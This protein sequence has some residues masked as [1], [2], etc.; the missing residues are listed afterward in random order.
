M[1]YYIIVSI[2]VI[3]ALLFYTFM[4]NNIE[5]FSNYLNTNKS[6]TVNLPINTTTS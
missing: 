1:K 4:Q 5:S 2:I 3:L 6:Y